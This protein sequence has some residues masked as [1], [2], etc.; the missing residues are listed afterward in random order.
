MTTLRAAFLLVFWVI[1]S[2]LLQAQAP[3][4][5]RL[6][7]ASTAYLINDAGDRSRFDHIAMELQKWKRFTLVDA[8][9]KADVFISFG[10]NVRGHVVAGSEVLPVA[11]Y[12]LTIRDRE[13]G[14]VLWNENTT[15]TGAEKRLVEH[16]RERLAS[17][18]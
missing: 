3:A 1:L 16:L 13:T 15:K 4:Q 11:G 7:K 5:E 10:K 2:G 12:S 6:F 9:E 14:V 17:V 18:Q 8:L